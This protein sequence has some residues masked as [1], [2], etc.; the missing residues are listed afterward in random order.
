VNLGERLPRTGFRPSRGQRLSL[1]LLLA[2]CLLLYRLEATPLAGLHAA[3][4]DRYQRLQPRQRDLQPAIVV[5]ID[6]RSIA[7]HGQ[8]PWPRDRIA[9]LLQRI[10]AGAPLAVGIDMVF[11][12][13]D[14]YHPQTLARQLPELPPAILAALPD[15]DRQLAQALAAGPSVLAVFGVR[16][17]LAGS[18]QPFRPLPGLVQGDAARPWL[19]D[20]VAGMASLPELEQAA[21]GEGLI[22][23]DAGSVAG[24]RTRGVLRQ[25]PAIAMIGQQPFL[26]L[27]LEMVRLALGE[28][29]KVHLESGRR[30]IERIHVGDYSLPTLP[31]GDLLLHFGRARSHYYLSASD[32][33]A[34]RV[35]PETFQSRLVL[36]GLNASGLQDRVITPLGDSLPGVDIHVQVIES[37]LAGT[38]LQRPPWLPWLEVAGLAVGGLLLI[39]LLPILKPRYA[40]LLFV[41]LALVGIGSGH[42]LFHFTGYLF[43]ASA[44]VLLLMPVF[45]ALLSATWITAD[46]QRRRAEHALH[47]SR[48]AAARIG[49]ELDAAKRIQLGLLPDPDREFAA[50]HRFEL[51]ALLEPARAVG[52][53]FYDCFLLDRRRLCIAIADVSG[54]GLPASLFMAVAT[55]LTGALVRRCNDLGLALQEVETELNRHNPEML[56]VTAFVAILDLDTGMLDYVRAGHEAPLLLRDGQVRRIDDAAAG[57]PP[58]CALGDFPYR[59]ARFS[60]QPDDNICLFTDGIIEASDGRA[61]FGISRL[62]DVWQTAAATPSLSHQPS[63]I[64]DAVRRFESGRAPTD[65]LA[66][67]L[68]RWRGAKSC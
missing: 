62:V 22:N 36:V 61:A 48:E 40:V 15:P 32:V 26:G 43:D 46:M 12:E 44:I 42:A 11:A 35:A 17:A 23:A 31:N 58:L 68:L 45:I 65:D 7:E 55:T 4:F 54:K 21:G 13:R 27:P 47:A 14:A 1:L 6:S 64:R 24:D 9:R 51:A 53:D 10:H 33:L 2:A 63:M 67:L 18:R 50:E 38:A 28:A 39:L 60:M 34:G 49:G 16:Q 20:F 59:S 41:G 30:G 29:G 19:T 3:Q 66:L 8:W 57:G 56:F 52:G 5:E 37:L 25:V